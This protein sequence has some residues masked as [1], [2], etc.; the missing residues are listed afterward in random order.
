M[1]EKWVLYI[2]EPNMPQRVHAIIFPREHR[3]I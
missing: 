3:I 1:S 2:I